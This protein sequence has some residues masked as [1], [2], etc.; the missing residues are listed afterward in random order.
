MISK[1]FFFDAFASRPRPLATQIL[2]PAVNRDGDRLREF[3][4]KKTSPE[5]TVHEIRAEVEGNLWMLTPEA[6]RYFLPAF[7][8]TALASYASVSVFASELVAAL[9]EPSR[10]DIVESLDRLN[11]IPP[12][13]GLPK[14]M[15][16]L[17]RKQQLEWFD[18]GI[19]E[20]IFHE[21]VDSLTAAEGAAILAFFG[22]FKETHGLNFPFRELEIAVDR[23]WARY[24][25]P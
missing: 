20:A 17:F 14:D 16:E 18:S 5:L 19:P 23:Y 21:R 11:Q 13:L 4:A 2:R 24:R 7:L 12:G 25:A 15:T 22:A 6:F 10:A 1:E 3:L 9:T 8:H